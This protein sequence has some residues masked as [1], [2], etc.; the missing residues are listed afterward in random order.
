MNKIVEE[1]RKD[2]Q[3]GINL[4]MGTLEQY[5]YERAEDWSDFQKVDAMEILD[6]CIAEVRFGE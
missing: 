4:V 3:R 2:R 5:L 1:A 6:A